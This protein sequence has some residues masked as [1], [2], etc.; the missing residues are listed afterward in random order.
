M[1]SHE[2]RDIYS[3]FDFGKS[4]RKYERWYTTPEGQ[5]HDNVQKSDVRRFLGPAPSGA[6]LLE[7][8]CGTG[9]WS[10]FLALLGYTVA[11][12]DSA[13]EMIRV[14]HGRHI[15]GVTVHVAEANMLPFPD[16][17][18]DVAAAITVLEFLFKPEAAV[19]EMARCVKAKGRILIGSLNRLAPMNGQRLAEKREPYISGHLFSPDELAALL[20]PFGAVRM[21]ASEPE[22]EGK[23]DL[24]GTGETESSRARLTGPLIIAEVQL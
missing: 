20:Q 17:W 5:T 3:V 2:Q 15:S 1:T 11:A 23:N 4:A 13:L 9:H 10:H 7:I 6:R 8:G 16:A 21:I 19:R 14:A 24:N 22:E 18:F 12:V